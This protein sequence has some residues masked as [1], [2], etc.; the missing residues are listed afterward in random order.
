L[1]NIF[2]LVTKINYLKL[3]IKL[4][5]I[6]WRHLSYCC[7]QHF[8]KPMFVTVILQSLNSKGL[9]IRSKN[10]WS[11]QIQKLIVFKEPPS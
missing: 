5:I 7:S 3:F 9:H 4:F 11:M 8:I 10:H 2:D 1:I 6:Q